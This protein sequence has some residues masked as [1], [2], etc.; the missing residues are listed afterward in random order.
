MESVIDMS[1]D[2]SYV[3]FQATVSSDWGSTFVRA[4]TCKDFTTALTAI[5]PRS[6][7]VTVIASKLKDGVWLIKALR[8]RGYNAFAGQRKEEE[9]SEDKTHERDRT[10]SAP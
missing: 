10:G 3:E 1:K 2:E 5:L 9:C 7:T 6:E 4:E 8:E